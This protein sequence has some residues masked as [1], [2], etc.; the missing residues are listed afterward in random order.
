M[1]IKRLLK[2]KSRSELIHILTCRGYRRTSRASGGLSRIDRP[3][4]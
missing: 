4:W 2:T 1:N 3:D